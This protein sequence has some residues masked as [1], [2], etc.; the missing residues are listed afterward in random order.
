MQG[1]CI[2]KWAWNYQAGTQYCQM[3]NNVKPT[4]GDVRSASLDSD[5]KNFVVLVNILK[6][7]AKIKTGQMCAH[8]TSFCNIFYKTKQFFAEMFVPLCTTH[9]YI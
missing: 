7:L 1:D 8:F 6:F 4:L 3:A 2:L 9:N 5:L